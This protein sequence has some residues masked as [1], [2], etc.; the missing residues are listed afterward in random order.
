MIIRY[1][2]ILFFTCILYNS[3]AQ[4]SYSKENLQDYVN[5]YMTFKQEKKNSS[6]IDSKYFYDHK[7]SRIRYHEI[8]KLALANEPLD[9]KANEKELLGELKKQNKILDVSNDKLL[10]SI[11]KEHSLSHDLYLEILNK[12]QTDIQFQRSLKPYFDIYIQKLK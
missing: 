1:L 6:E 4:N 11:C 7:V 2:Q 12:Y 3:N 9:L 5:A 8:T 10:R